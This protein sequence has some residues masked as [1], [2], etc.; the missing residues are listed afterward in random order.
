MYYFQ[1]EIWE[2]MKQKKSGI[3]VLTKP[4]CGKLEP[5][6]MKTIH[7]YAYADTWGEYN[8]EISINIIGLEEFTFSVR[9]Q[10]EDLPISYPICRNLPSTR[11]FLR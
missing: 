11:P 3:V 6:E 9:I 10:V 1:D 4:S 2:R 7:I 5:F 8:E